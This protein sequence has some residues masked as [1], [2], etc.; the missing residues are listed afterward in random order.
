[1]LEVADERRRKEIYQAL[2]PETRHGGDRT[3]RQIGD[4]KDARFTADTAA[5]TGRSERDVQRDATR[6]ERIPEPVLAEVRYTAPTSMA[7]MPSTRARM[8]PHIKAR[9]TLVCDPAARS[10]ATRVSGP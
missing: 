5:K 1:M 4:M 9:A 7:K 2:H 6:G 8:A 10:L 3:S